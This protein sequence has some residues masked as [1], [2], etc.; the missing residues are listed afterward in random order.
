MPASIRTDGERGALAQAFESVPVGVALLGS[1]RRYVAANP[2]LQK[3]TGYT[4]AELRHLSPADIT[5]EDDQAATEAIIA[6]NA[7]G[8]PLHGVSRSATGARM[9]V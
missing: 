5:H 3:M 2:A 8:E 4:E 1:D 9:A 6:A 7:A